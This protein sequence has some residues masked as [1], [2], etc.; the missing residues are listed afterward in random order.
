MRR[1]ML[2]SP[3][4]VQ[5]FPRRLEAVDVPGVGELVLLEEDAAHPG[6]HPDHQKD[7]HEQEG[8]EDEGMSVHDTG[9]STQPP[10]PGRESP[11]PVH[12]DDGPYFLQ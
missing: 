3:A 11:L 2:C 4:L 1:L 10:V 6:L 7:G 5:Q 12:A 9:A 8:I